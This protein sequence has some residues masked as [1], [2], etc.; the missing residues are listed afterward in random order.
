MAPLRQAESLQFQSPGQRPG[1]DGGEDAIETGESEG[2][3]K[4]D[5]R[6]VRPLG[7]WF[8][9]DDPE[10]SPRALELH[11]FRVLEEDVNGMR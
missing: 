7:I 6:A 9:L 3:S 8:G 5:L 10:V 11:P 1:E 4:V 2:G